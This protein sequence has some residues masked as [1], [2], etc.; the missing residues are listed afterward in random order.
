MHWCDVRVVQFSQ[1]HQ[2]NSLTICGS[3]CLSPIPIILIRQT[4]SHSSLSSVA[5][6]SICVAGLVVCTISS[7][8]SSS[9]SMISATHGHG[10]SDSYRAHGRSPHTLLYRAGQ[11][12]IGF[13]RHAYS[14]RGPHSIG[15]SMRPFSNVIITKCGISFMSQT[16][17]QTGTSH[18]HVP[19]VL[20]T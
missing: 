18:Q 3:V 14:G 2:H 6:M 4:P 15:G 13:V 9:Q 16:Q 19:V 20:P 5:D 17:T 8:S 1:L 7:L 12:R 10:S 11:C